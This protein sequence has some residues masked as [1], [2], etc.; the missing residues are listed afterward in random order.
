MPLSE[1]TSDAVAGAFDVRLFRA[2]ADDGLLNAFVGNDEVCALSNDE[3]GL[4]GFVQML[5]DCGQLSGSR[6]FDQERAG[7]AEPERGVVAEQSGF[8]DE[9]LREKSLDFRCQFHGR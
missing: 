4:S 1:T 7:A 6:A 3:E 9:Q 2:E 5:N 8:A